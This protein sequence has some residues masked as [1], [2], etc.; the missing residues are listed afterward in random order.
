MK[1][2]TPSP[3]CF[4]ALMTHEA[5]SINE[6]AYPDALRNPANPLT[7]W[8]S[9]TRNIMSLL[10]NRPARDLSV[11]AVEM[12]LEYQP[13]MLSQSMK[14]NALPALLSNTQLCPE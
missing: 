5:I 14:L 13:G 7:A 12:S 11:L 10:K 3:S 9:G 2:R 8:H 4:I 6:N 1:M